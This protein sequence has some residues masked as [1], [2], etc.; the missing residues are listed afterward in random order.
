MKHYL[1]SISI[2]SGL[3]GSSCFADIPIIVNT[4]TAGEIDISLELTDENYSDLEIEKI[5]SIFQQSTGNPCYV[6]R[7]VSRSRLVFHDLA[8]Q[9]SKSTDESMNLANRSFSARIIAEDQTT[10]G[11]MHH[12][13]GFGWRAPPIVA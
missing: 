9:A 10:L 4:N 6:D 1:I 11:M 12:Q 2:I 7:S 13:G 8:N 5:E 3:Y